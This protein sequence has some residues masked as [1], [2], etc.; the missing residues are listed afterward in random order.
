LKLT[1]SGTGETFGGE[2]DCVDCCG[3]WAGFHQGFQVE[4]KEEEV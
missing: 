2:F 1:P 3:V 4:F